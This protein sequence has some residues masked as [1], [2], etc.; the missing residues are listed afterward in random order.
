ML[1]QNLMKITGVKIRIVWMRYKQDRTKR[2][3]EEIIKNY[4]VKI[5]KN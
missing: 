3:K 4:K 2:A 1:Y 5:S